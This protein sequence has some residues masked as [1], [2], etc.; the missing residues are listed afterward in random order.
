MFLLRQGE[1][2]GTRVGEFLLIATAGETVL[3]ELFFSSIVS[4]ILFFLC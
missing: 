3:D 1:R 2:E 4:L